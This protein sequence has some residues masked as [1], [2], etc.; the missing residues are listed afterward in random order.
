M[1]EY[2]LTSRALRDLTAIVTYLTEEASP[3]IALRTEDKLFQLFESLAQHPGI[4]HRRSD[5]TPRNVRFHPMRPY[6]VVYEP[7]VSPILIHAVLH[8]ARDITA[9]LKNR[10]S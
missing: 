6:M 2:S 3:A 7:G 8:S 4:G 1:P 10:I 9:I 5:I